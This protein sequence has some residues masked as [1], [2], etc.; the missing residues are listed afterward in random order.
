MIRVKRHKVHCAIQAYHSMPQE[1]T[2]PQLLINTLGLVPVLTR[3]LYDYD[4]EKQKHPT[5]ICEVS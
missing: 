5:I 3:V 2:D 4:G 1:R